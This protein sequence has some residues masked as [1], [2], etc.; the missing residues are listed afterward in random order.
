M[1]AGMNQEKLE[2]FHKKAARIQSLINEINELLKIDVGDDNSVIE[3]K[4]RHTGRRLF[5]DYLL[6]KIIATGSQVLLEQN[7]KELEELLG[8]MA[9]SPNTTK[10]KSKNEF[11][12]QTA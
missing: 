9:T 6:R 8:E 12:C 2:A 3:I 1:E 7:E 10:A 4:C 5:C 11:F